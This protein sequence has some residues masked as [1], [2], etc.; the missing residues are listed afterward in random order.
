MLYFFKV[1]VLHDE[2]SADELWDLWEKETEAA[3]GGMEAGLIKAA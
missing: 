3:K 2:M 1:R